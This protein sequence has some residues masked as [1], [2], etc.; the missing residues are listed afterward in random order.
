MEYKYRS[1]KIGDV[2]EIDE[3]SILILSKDIR[4]TPK[5]TGVCPVKN[6]KLSPIGCNKHPLVGLVIGTGR[7]V[8]RRFTEV[9]SKKKMPNE[10]N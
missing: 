5:L 8:C 7:I 6:C 1:I 4:E 10:T 3:E 2:V 9:E